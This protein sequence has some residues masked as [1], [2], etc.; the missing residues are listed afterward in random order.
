LLLHGGWSRWRKRRWGRS[1]ARGGND[2][3]GIF[4]AELFDGGSQGATSCRAARTH[5]DLGLGE[6]AMWSTA[7]KD[8]SSWSTPV[9]SGNIGSGAVS[10][11]GFRT[12]IWWQRRS[13][14]KR[15]QRLNVVDHTE[16]TRGGWCRTCRSRRLVDLRVDGH[17]MAA[18]H[19]EDLG[20][21]GVALRC[22]ARFTVT[23]RSAVWWQHHSAGC[24]HRVPLGLY[25]AASGARRG[26]ARL[27]VQGDA[28]TTV[29][30]EGFAPKERR[31]EV[32]RW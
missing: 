10:R 18:S 5:W 17:R 21:T 23:S 12:P 19:L 28:S 2:S 30:L 4:A 24:E 22:I 13:G 1:A 31:E 26:Q 25:P 16:P 11:C 9:A 14:R 3:F 15:P 32:R 6:E 29:A 27:P 20:P 8:G 7:P